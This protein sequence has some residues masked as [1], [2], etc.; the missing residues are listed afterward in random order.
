VHDRRQLG[1][2]DDHRPHASSGADFAGAWEKQRRLAACLGEQLVGVDP[3]GWAC[4]GDVLRSDGRTELAKRA[5]HPRDRVVVGVDRG[6]DRR[7]FGCRDRK[8][9]DRRG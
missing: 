3:A 8:M 4:N 1:V 9:L 6:G 5:E 2:W 7:S